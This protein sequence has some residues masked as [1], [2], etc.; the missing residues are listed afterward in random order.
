MGGPY[1]RYVPDI[2]DLEKK[3]KKTIWELYHKV[4]ILIGPSDSIKYIKKV[5]EEYGK[6]EK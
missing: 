2:E 4:E 6:E 3:D 1:K 5:L